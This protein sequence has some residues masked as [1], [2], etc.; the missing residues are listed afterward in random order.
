MTPEE[1]LKLNLSRGILVD[2]ED[3]HWLRLKLWLIDPRGYCSAKFE[4]GRKLLHRLIL[5]YTGQQVVDHINGMPQ[6]N[7]RLNLRLSSKSENKQNQR[8]KRAGCSSRF[9]GVHYNKARAR[10]DARIHVAHRFLA[11]GSFAIEQ[12]AAD[13]YDRAAIQYF[14]EFAATNKELIK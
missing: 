14:G 12:E 1:R 13:A 5:N 3:Q 11:L 10:W 6:D 9:K 2:L 8:R 7:R 4:T